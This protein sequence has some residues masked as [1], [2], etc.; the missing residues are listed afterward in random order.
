[1][2]LFYTYK[3]TLNNKNNERL[4]RKL[5][6]TG[7]LDNLWTKSPVGDKNDLNSLSFFLII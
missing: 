7:D 3:F 5:S 1:M 6:P 4:A 2:L